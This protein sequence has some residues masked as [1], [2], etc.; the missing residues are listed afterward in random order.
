MANPKSHHLDNP[1]AHVLV[2]I[3]QQ[4]R[5][6]SYTTTYE[7]GTTGATVH[8][9][10]Y[11]KNPKDAGEKGEVRSML[12]EEWAKPENPIVLPPEAGTL[13]I[14]FDALVGTDAAL[15]PQE[16]ADLLRSLGGVD[17]AG[18]VLAVGAWAR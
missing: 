12:Y 16:A 13:P 4:P 6:A 17:S 1:E 2:I 9:L 3:D 18:R 5:E 7:D 10:Y 11:D 14:T 15:L 8:V